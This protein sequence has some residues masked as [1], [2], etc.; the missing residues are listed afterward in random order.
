[1]L[2]VNPQ[3][4]ELKYFMY[5]R[6]VSMVCMVC[7][8]SPSLVTHGSIWSLVVTKKDEQWMLSTNDVVCFCEN[9]IDT[10]REGLFND[11]FE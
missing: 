10:N 9:F 8:Q 5:E 6:V 11:T 4:V 3:N 1:M 2:H 7:K